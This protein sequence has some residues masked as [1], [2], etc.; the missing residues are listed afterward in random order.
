MKGDHKKV[1][2]TSSLLASID[3]ISWM[4]Y[5]FHINEN[6]RG[7]VTVT[8]MLKINLTVLGLQLL[9]KC[10]NFLFNL[11][12]APLATTLLKKELLHASDS[13]SPVR[14]VVNSKGYW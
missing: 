14:Y 8:K 4:I 2:S 13:I 11:K 1:F 10:L 6:R 5:L 3:I 12:P 7:A 9:N